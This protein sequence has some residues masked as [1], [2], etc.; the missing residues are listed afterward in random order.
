MPLDLKTFTAIHVIISLLAIASGLVVVFGLIARKRLDSLTAFF[1]VTT[2]ATSV[3][4]FGFPIHGV[5]PGIVLGVISLVVLAIA[6]YARYVGHLAG[7]WR[8]VY[9][10]TAVVALYLNV[11]VLIA[12]SFQKVPVLNALAPTG[13][14]P[15][16]AIA[17]AVALAAFIALGILGGKRFRTQ[18][19]PVA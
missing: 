18:P 1:L 3:T 6:V 12:Q 7:R 19:T 13:S 14:E 11:F 17:Q 5:T 4:G 16:F 10:V 2:I 9:V 8:L 15:P